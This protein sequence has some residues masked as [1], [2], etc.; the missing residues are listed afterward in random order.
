MSIFQRIPVLLPLVALAFASVHLAF[1]YFTGGV[2]GHHALNQSDL[3]VISNWLG[4]L[5]LPLLGFALWL[6]IRSQVSREYLAGFPRSVLAALVGGC[7]YGVVLSVAF[8]LNATVIMNAASVGFL[9]LAVALPVYRVEYITGF[10]V[11]MTFT[12]GG[13]LPLLVALVVAAIS[14]AVR[15]LVRSAVALVRKMR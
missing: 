8:E 13:V 3:P 2:K 11:G 5:T 7:L 14:F 15:Y 9:V 10:V 1:E 4:L 6:R 12:F